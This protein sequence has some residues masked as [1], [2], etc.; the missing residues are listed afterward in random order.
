MFPQD[1]NLTQVCERLVDALR[2]H[3]AAMSTIESAEPMKSMPMINALRTAALA[4]VETVLQETG[5]GNVFDDLY[6]EKASDD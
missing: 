2:D 4:Y 6:Q 1:S 3:A 5:W